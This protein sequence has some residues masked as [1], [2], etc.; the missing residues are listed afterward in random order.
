[1]ALISVEVD[2]MAVSAVQAGMVEGMEAKNQ[3]LAATPARIVPGPSVTFSYSLSGGSSSFHG[4]EDALTAGRVKPKVITRELQILSTPFSLSNKTRDLY[5]SPTDQLQAQIKGNLGSHSR[6]LAGS[7][8][9]GDGTGYN[10]FGFAGLITA[11]EGIT[12]STVGTLTRAGLDRILDTYT[13]DH[14]NWA[15]VGNA[16]VA[17]KFRDVTTAVGGTTYETLAGTALNAPT[18][19]GIPF[20]VDSACTSVSGASDAFLVNLDWEE[21]FGLAYGV[22]NADDN[23]IGN[24]GPFAVIDMG[25]ADGVKLVKSWVLSCYVQTVLRSKQALIK[26]P[27]VSV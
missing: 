8:I 26:L 27:G 17:S 23:I 16:D 6:K 3:L 10:P 21:G 2:G 9:T 1:M 19:R 7:L 14:G 13:F 15:F 12:A 5:S 25:Y 18:Y 24:E 11:G 4:E 20:L 22:M